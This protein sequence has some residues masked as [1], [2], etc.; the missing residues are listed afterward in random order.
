[1]HTLNYGTSYSLDEIKTKDNIMK[2][3]PS[4]C[5][6]GTF[7]PRC[8]KQECIEEMFR[9]ED[10]AT[11]KHGLLTG[12]PTCR[13]QGK[14]NMSIENPTNFQELLEAFNM[15]DKK[16]LEDYTDFAVN[17]GIE[18][19]ISLLENRLLIVGVCLNKALTLL[20]E[21]DA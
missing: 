21:K 4:I 17:K 18:D 2:K 19:R 8:E 9:A 13:K 20:A 10:A 11:C 6:H 12:C 5:P 3:D 14:K 15:A 16:E 7:Y 1:M